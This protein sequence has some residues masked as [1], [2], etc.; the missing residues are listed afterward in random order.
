MRGKNPLLCCV[1]FYKALEFGHYKRLVVEQGDVL[2]WRQNYSNVIINLCTKWHA[3]IE[4][5]LAVDGFFC[6][7]NV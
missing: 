5:I 6:G 3:C 1:T 4:A 7:E 2:G